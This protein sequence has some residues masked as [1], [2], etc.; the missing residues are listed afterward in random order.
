MDNRLCEI[1]RSRRTCDGST[2]IA[3]VVLKNKLFVANAGD[4]RAVCGMN[5]GSTK[6]MSWDQTCD[7]ADEAERVRN[8]GGVV[9]RAGGVARINGELVPSRAFGDPEYKEGTAPHPVTASP[10]I[11]VLDMDATPPKFAVLACDGLWDVCS[12]ETAVTLVNRYLERGATPQKIS[13]ALVDY[14]LREGSTDNVTVQILLFGGA[15]AAKKPPARASA[16]PMPRR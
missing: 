13:K 10:E 3:A 8:A 12:N 7:R 11:S 15:A 1:L 16:V 9:R 2:C 6:A 4:S 14:A 5:D